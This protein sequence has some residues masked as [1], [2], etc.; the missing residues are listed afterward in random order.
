MDFY[1]SIVKYSKIVLNHR[2]FVDNLNY[3]VAWSALISHTRANVRNLVVSEEIK[4]HLSSMDIETFKQY[5]ISL[6]VTPERSPPK[7]SRDGNVT[8]RQPITRRRTAPALEICHTSNT[9]NP[10][11]ATLK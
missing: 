2:T 8:L 9:H 1:F 11:Y 4:K 10:L 3:L 5:E 6:E 7:Y